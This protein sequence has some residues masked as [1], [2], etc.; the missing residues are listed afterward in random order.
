MAQSPMD[1]ALTKLGKGEAPD[2]DDLKKYLAT[3]GANLDPKTTAWCAAFV[4]SSLAQAGITGT[5]SNMA[6][7]FLKWGEAVEQPQKGDLAVFSRGNPNSPFGHVA[8]YDSTT[9]DGR[10]RVLGGNQSDAVSY[11]N[12]DPGKLLGYRR[13]PEG[14]PT[15]SSQIAA[16][17]SQSAPQQAPGSPAPALPSPINVNDRPI[18]QPQAPA[19]TPPPG[20]LAALGGGDAPAS[21]G[22]MDGIMQ[23]LMASSQGQEQ[24]QPMQLQ[25]MRPAQPNQ[26]GLAE[27][28]AQFMQS[29]TV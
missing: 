23:M 13:A 10:I 20:I 11:A 12:Y 8:F 22:G 28:I 1:F 14:G 15:I 16:N 24:P 21:G 9:P 4:N 5:G 27:Y 7:S 29:R 6:R 18:G 2:R 25:P 26:P 19:Q 3:G 17:P